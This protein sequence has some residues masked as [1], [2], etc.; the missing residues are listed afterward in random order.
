MTAKGPST[1][2]IG[3]GNPER[4]DDAAGRVV[5]RRLAGALPEG[6]E[7]AEHDGE[8]TSLLA[9][10]EGTGTV[11]CVDACLS[12]EAPGTVHRFDVAAAPLPDAAFGIS[13]HGFGLGE[14]LEL[15]RTLGVLPPRAIV[16]AIEGKSFATGASLSAP[17]EAAVAD[18]ADRLRAE[19]AG[20]EAANA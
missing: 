14:A 2:V 9:R 7:V 16:Y 5:A 1:L 12:G 13:T 19:I 20:A 3:I 17:V 4:G 11:Y 6:V 15:A 8:A 18:V 10:I